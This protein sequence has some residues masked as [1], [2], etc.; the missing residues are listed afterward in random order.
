[1]EASL[2]VARRLC[3][4][5]RNG[6]KLK[7]EWQRTDFFPVKFALGAIRR[8]P[9]FWLLA[10]GAFCALLMAVAVIGAYFVQRRAS[11]PIGEG[12]VFVDDS[13][14][15]GSIIAAAPDLDTGARG[16]RNSIDIEAV[17]VVDP[18]GVVVASTSG[19]MVGGMVPNDLIAF[20]A[21]EHRFA[22]LAGAID[23][24]LTLDEV[25]TWP[26]GSVL[27]QVTSPLEGSEDSVLLYYD[28]AKL[29]GRRTP[30]GS[31]EPETIQL[32]VLAGIFALLSV[33]MFLGHTRASRRYREVEMESDLLRKHSAEL[34]LANA[35]LSTARHQAEE[36]LELA[37]EKIRIRSE[38]V[39]MINHELRT[40]LTSVVTGA[41]LMQAMSLTDP[42]RDGLLDSMVRESER[43]QEII[44]QILAVA[45]IENRGLSYQLSEVTIED[46]C[47]AALEAHPAAQTSPLE[48][49]HDDSVALTDTSALR[50]VIASLVDNAL[51][52]GATR[53]R[54]GCGR[55]P[56]IAPDLEVGER[57][58]SAVY[59]SVSDD[60]PGIEPGFL[61]RIFEKFEKSS[62]S[63]GT[64]LGLYLARLIIEALQG[65]IAVRGL[66]RPTT[67]EIAIPV[68]KV[69]QPVRADR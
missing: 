48:H 6:A 16:A 45:R 30:P 1:V 53:V 22:A 11:A 26:A 33:I 9:A 47:R 57:P 58:E 36:A 54:V 39:L 65:S 4:E 37:E 18:E 63:S 19:P 7:N 62:F 46:L 32:L 56:T 14:E 43:L 55:H 41:R 40:P 49:Y 52:H 10:L 28:V 8:R 42:E 5:T 67:F 69:R 17:S 60:G 59:I 15:A 38:F 21:T 27:Y 29:L 68:T 51:T 44:D 12:V 31:V 24:D 35:E 3:V 13:A 64:G 34:Q 61:P 66:T 50:M 2:G 23:Q 20:G 25:V